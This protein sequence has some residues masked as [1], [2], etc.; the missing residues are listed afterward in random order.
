ML[1]RL[2]RLLLKLRRLL[3]RLLLKL[4]RL[5]LRRLLRLLLNLR[6]LL[7]RLLLLLLTWRL[8]TGLLWLELV[9]QSKGASGDRRR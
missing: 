1:R 2:L 7:V 6:R 3:L 9:H 8:L 5:L 4:R